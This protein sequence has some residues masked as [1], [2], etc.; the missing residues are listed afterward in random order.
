[1]AIDKELEA[2]ILR[3][4][5]VEKWRLNTIAAQLHIHHSVVDRV[6]SQ[7]GLP[8]VERAARPSKLDP[9]LP[10]IM[11]TLEC[12]PKLTAARLYG[13][14]MERGYSGGPSHFRACI[15]QR[16]PRPAAEAYLR[17]KT[18][19]TPDKKTMFINVQHPGATTTPAQFSEGDIAGR[20]PDYDDRYYPRS[21]TVVITK[22]DGGVIGS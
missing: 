16:R 11:A 5:F 20:W 13:M 22:D 12:Y 2:K 19:T 8:K 7:A 1:M 18:L 14:A 17:L 10:F 21:A 9:Y 15:A 4:H 3:Y 6:L